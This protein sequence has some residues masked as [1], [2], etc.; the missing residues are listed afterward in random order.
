[1]LTETA[2]RT[3]WMTDAQLEVDAHL[4]VIW[5]LT[6]PK[7]PD[8]AQTPG[9]PETPNTCQTLGDRRTSN[10]RRHQADKSSGRAAVLRTA[11]SLAP[12]G[13]HIVNGEQ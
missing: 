1:M 2:G 3:F 4:E 13:L 7:R 8:D 6:G 12:S 11:V 10:R 5:G 9:G